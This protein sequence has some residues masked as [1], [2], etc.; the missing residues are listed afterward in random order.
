MEDGL[1]AESESADFERVVFL[2]A[3]LKHFDSAPVDFRE[4][5]VIVSV[6]RWTL[7]HQQGNTR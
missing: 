2:D 5:R 1:E 7:Q 4:S 6:K 3:L